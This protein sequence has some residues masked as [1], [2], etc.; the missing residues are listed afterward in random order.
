VGR[1]PKW[2]N[3]Y[4]GPY[5]IVEVLGAVNLRIQKSAKAAAMVVHVDKVKRCMGDTPVSWMGTGERDI[6]F[7]ALED[8]RVL[9]P[10]FVEDPYVRTADIINDIDDGRML[11]VMVHPKRNAH[12]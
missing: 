6:T 9:V 1:S 4:S 3:F 5:L 7:G 11:P 12:I 10:F 8:D 2:Q